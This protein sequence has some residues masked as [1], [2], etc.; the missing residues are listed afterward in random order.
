MALAFIPE[1]EVDIAL[2][3]LCTDTP[4]DLNLDEFAEYMDRTG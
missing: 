4:D 2:Q 3:S 1:W